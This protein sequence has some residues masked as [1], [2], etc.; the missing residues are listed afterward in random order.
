MIIIMIIIGIVIGGLIFLG[1]VIFVVISYLAYRNRNYFTK[2]DFKAEETTTTT[3]IAMNEM[4]ES[5]M[6]LL[7]HSDSSV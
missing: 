7:K 1:I 3:T 4:S 2:E 6:S 5:P